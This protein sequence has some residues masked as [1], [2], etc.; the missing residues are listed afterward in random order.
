MHFHQQCLTS[1]KQKSISEVGCR[2]LFGDFFDKQHVVDS[3]NTL[4]SKRPMHRRLYLWILLT[5]M[6]FYT[7]QRDER[8]YT[9]LYT[10]YKFGWGT[11][12]FS[13]FKVFQTTAYI[14]MLFGGV[15]IMTKL[16]KWQDT[17]I[18][19]IGATF[20][21]A[22]RIFYAFAQVPWIFYVGALISCIGPVGG[23]IIRS[24]TSKVVPA[25]ER[26]KVFALL[27]VCDNAVPLVSGVLYT[28][29]YNLTVGIFPGIF[30]LTA[31]SQSILFVLML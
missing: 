18:A 29:V 6:F 19:M 25:A 23:P 9:Y 22:S 20:F 17:I 4:I 31:I 3:V 26:G 15:P 8:S 11:E 21:T 27:A 16:F 10:Q 2:G 14:L 1:P 28:Q 7:F 13:N 30:W 24:M 12:Q 5:A